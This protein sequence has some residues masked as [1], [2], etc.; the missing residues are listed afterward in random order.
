[1]CLKIAY[2]H[3]FLSSL[4]IFNASFF[5]LIFPQYLYTST[6]IGLISLANFSNILLILFFVSPCLNT[7]TVSDFYL[8]K[9]IYYSFVYL[10]LKFLFFN[11]G[12]LMSQN[13]I[14][15][16][17]RW[18]QIATTYLDNPFWNIKLEVPIWL[19][20]YFCTYFTVGLIDFFLTI[21]ILEQFFQ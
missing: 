9:K 8:T 2:S 19:L 4:C 3:S 13:V 1:L 15:K 17:G 20:K 10:F 7:V 12:F 6:P 18:S 16:I 21:N 14:L 11:D 5:K